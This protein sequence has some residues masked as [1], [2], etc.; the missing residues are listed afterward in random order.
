[1]LKWGGITFG[2]GVALMIVDIYLAYRKEEG[3]TPIDR[4]RVVGIF[5]LTLFASALVAGL[6]WMTPE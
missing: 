6:I 1:M 3:F 4:Q 2:L 5:W